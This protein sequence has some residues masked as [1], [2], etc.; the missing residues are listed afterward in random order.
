MFLFM[1]SPLGVAVS[2]RSLLPILNAGP[3]DY[4]AFVVNEKVGYPQPI[5]PLQLGICRYSNCPF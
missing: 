2:S 5:K 3:F 4:T 1:T